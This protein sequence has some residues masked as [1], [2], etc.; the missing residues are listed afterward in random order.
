MTAGGFYLYSCKSYPATATTSPNGSMLRYLTGVRV[1][2]TDNPIP[3]PYDFIVDSWSTRSS[4]LR[5]TGTSVAISLLSASTYTAYFNDISVKQITLSTCFHTPATLPTADVTIETSFQMVAGLQ[6]GVVF[7]LNEAGTS[8]IIAYHDG[9]GNIKLEI[10][11]AGTY[12]TKATVAATYVSDATL[13]VRRDGVVVWVWYNNV[14]IGAGPTTTLS[15][16]ENTNLRGTKAGLFSTSELNSFNH[17]LINYTGTNG[18]YNA[19][20][21]LVGV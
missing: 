6:A 19:I 5:N 12:T 9:A 14:L 13:R 11:E 1:D 16:G 17:C 4:S 18:E 15:A 3:D 2:S 20:D 21:V 8:F 7:G 10:C